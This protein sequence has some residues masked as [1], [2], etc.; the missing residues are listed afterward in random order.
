MKYL[1]RVVWSEGMYLGPHH[2]QVQSRYFEDTIR[3]ATSSLWFEAW[4]FAACALDPEAL[5]NGTISLLHARGMFPD[6]LAF[7]M[8]ESDPVPEPRA[9]GDL[10]PPNRESITVLLTV[11]ERRQNGLNC[12]PA[13]AANGQHTRFVAEKRL[14]HD[15]TTGVDEK[16]VPL[17]RKNISLTLDTESLEGLQSIPVARVTRI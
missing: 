11:P 14:L 13:E 10:F 16:L 12:V 17:G 3:F 2:F 9:I 8:P 4:G 6:G 15:E 1:S 5:R 7:H